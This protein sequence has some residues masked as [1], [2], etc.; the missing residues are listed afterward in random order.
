M[1]ELRWI[2]ERRNV[3]EARQDLASWLGKWEKRYEKLCDWVE[4]NIEE[5]LTSTGCRRRITST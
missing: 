2:Y 3:E 5:T 4:N 1:T